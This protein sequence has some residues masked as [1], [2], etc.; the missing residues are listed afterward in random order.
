MKKH[1]SISR[2]M[3]TTQNIVLCERNTIINSVKYTHKQD[4]T[5]IEKENIGMY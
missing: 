1:G 4:G 3:S 2:D 5:G